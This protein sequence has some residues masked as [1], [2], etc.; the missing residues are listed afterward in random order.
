MERAEVKKRYAAGDSVLGEGEGMK[1][2]VD[3]WLGSRFKNV[4]Q[5]LDRHS[6]RLSFNLLSASFEDPVDSLRGTDPFYS[7][8]PPLPSPPCAYPSSPLAGPHAVLPTLLNDSSRAHVRR[9]RLDT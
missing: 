1:D 2:L 7:R 8:P 4:I 3:A 6:V 9:V 5:L